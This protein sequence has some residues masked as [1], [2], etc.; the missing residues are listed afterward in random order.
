MTIK[1]IS[2]KEYTTL[3]YEG[4]PEGFRYQ[5]TPI[6]LYDLKLIAPYLKTPTSLLRAEFSFMVHLTAGY[7]AQQVGN[8][9]KK[10]CHGAVLLAG[11]GQ[12]TSLL[13]VSKDIEGFFILFENSML[14]KLLVNKELQKLFIV[15]PLIRLPEESNR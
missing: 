7:F 10:V 2:F 4:M 1:N 12:I 13:H 9:I 6:Q 8:E 15:N 5:Q 11:H 3:F 14:N